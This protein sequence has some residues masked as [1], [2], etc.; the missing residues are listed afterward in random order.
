MAYL[1]IS[2][3]CDVYFI[4]STEG[5]F[6]CVGCKLDTYNSVFIQGTAN[7][8]VQERAVQHLQD[9]QDAGHKGI[10]NYTLDEVMGYLPRRHDLVLQELI[11]TAQ[12][13]DGK[14]MTRDADCPP[15]IRGEID[16]ALVAE[17]FLT[18]EVAV[19]EPMKQELAKALRDLLTEEEVDAFIAQL[20]K[21]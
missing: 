10:D 1:R 4:A 16:L 8:S 20:T 6:E 2:D 14:I 11:D 9:H 19:T 18:G 15:E 5:G 7:V 12:A 3:D 13:N 17:K 21:A